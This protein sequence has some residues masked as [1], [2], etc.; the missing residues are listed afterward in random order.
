MRKYAFSQALVKPASHLSHLARPIRGRPH[1]GYFSIQQSYTILHSFHVIQ[2][3]E[4]KLPKPAKKQQ[5]SKDPTPLAVVE[6]EDS[7]AKSSI[8]PSSSSSSCSEKEHDASAV[9]S[10]VPIPIAKYQHFCR[11]YFFLNP[12]T[13]SHN[14][15]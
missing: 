10:E 1:V 4:P 14:N 9:A 5:E 15:F 6:S 3:D 11:I 12:K 13:F 2:K 8:V 7:S